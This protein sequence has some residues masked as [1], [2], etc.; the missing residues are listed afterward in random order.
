MWIT[1]EFNFVIKKWV[2]KPKSY[3]NAGTE[4]Y[5]LG[6]LLETTDKAISSYVGE[7]SFLKNNFYL[8]KLNLNS[9]QGTLAERI[10]AGVQEFQHFLLL[11]ELVLWLLKIKKLEHLI[12]KII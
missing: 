11:Q 10:R 6:L 1:R 12:I 9:I 4:G 5:G 7:N 2:F 3:N 8:E